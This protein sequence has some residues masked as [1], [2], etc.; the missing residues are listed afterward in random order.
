AGYVALPTP[1]PDVDLPGWRASV[2]TLR[3]W[4]PTGLGLTH[5]G[6]AFDVERHLDALEAEIARFEALD[7]GIGRE[8][9]LHD[10]RRRLAGEVRDADPRDAYE[11]AVP[12]E[13]VW[14]G[15]ERYWTRRDEAAA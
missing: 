9:F 13:H 5:F 6:M 15:L 11:H 4:S 7:A 14:L 1:P 10:L 2:E 12:E 3:A 8:A